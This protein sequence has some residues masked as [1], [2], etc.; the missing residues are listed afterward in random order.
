MTRR[1]DEDQ[2]QEDN[3]NEED[4][5][6]ATKVIRISNLENDFS[7][8]EIIER[9]ELYCCSAQSTSS[10][11]HWKIHR[12]R[13]VDASTLDISISLRCHYGE[14]EYILTF[15]Q[16]ALSSDRDIDMEVLVESP[17]YL[18]L[19]DKKYTKED[20][21]LEKEHTECNRKRFDDL[22]LLVCDTRIDAHSLES[23]RDM[24]YRYVEQVEDHFQLHHPDIDYQNGAFSFQEIGSRS[25]LRYDVRIDMSR[26]DRWSSL[27]QVA[28]Q[29]GPWLNMVHV[30]FGEGNWKVEANVIY[31]KPGAKNQV[32]HCDGGHLEQEADWDGHGLAPPYALCVFLP[33]IDLNPRVGFTQ[34]FL[35]SH[36]TSQLVGFGPAAKWLAADFDGILCAGE[37]VMYDYRLMHR[38]MAN[39]E[40][41]RPIIQLLY[42]KHFYVETKNYGSVS[43]YANNSR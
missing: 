15:V 9:L 5:Q 26:D 6:R 36:K 37:S 33:L 42:T 8:E 43:M 19:M 21:L 1:Q 13:I 18:P 40:K 12:F 31:S 38:G 22:G 20:L 35:G 30:I 23:I 2:Q 29:T 16:N 34:F 39:E 32:W 7:A 28:E 4:W 10:H 27:H 25:G 3:N 17:G 24:A 41:L 11:R 14:D